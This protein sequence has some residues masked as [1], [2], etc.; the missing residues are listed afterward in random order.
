MQ[1]SFLLYTP[2]IEEPPPLVPAGPVTGI[3]QDI[4]PPVVSFARNSIL[5][6][7]QIPN[8]HQ[9]PH[10]NSPSVNPPL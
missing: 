6:G 8:P 2:G 7:G 9:G 10:S 4:G 1:M 5:S 3:S